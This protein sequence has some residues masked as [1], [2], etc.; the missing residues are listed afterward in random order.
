MDRVGVAAR[1]RKRVLESHTS[2]HRAVQL[3]RYAVEAAGGRTA[4]EPPPLD[5][6]E[7]AG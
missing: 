6:A 1:A 7:R 4:S 2:I 3:E 5:V